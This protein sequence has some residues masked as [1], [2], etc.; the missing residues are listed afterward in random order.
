MTIFASTFGAAVRVVAVITGVDLMA[1][2]MT[3]VYAAA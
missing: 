3:Q 2:K 1:P